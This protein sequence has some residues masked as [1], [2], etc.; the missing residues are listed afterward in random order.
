[1]LWNVKTDILYGEKDDTCEFDTI[2]NFTKR[3]DCNLEVVLEGEHYFH[4][5]EQLRIFQEWLQNTI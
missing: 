4:T 2:K 1:M 3:F 5:K